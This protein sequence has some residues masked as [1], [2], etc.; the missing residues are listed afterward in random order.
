MHDILSCT[1]AQFELR[2][3]NGVEE[4][5]GRIEVYHNEQ[6]GTVCDDEWDANDAMVVCKQLNYTGGFARKEAAF[7]A[8]S[9]PIWLD[10]VVCSGTELTLHE[11]SH[12]GWGINDCS[13][14]ED[15]GVKCFNIGKV[16]LYITIFL[17]EL[18]N[19][20]IDLYYKGNIALII[21]I[22]TYVNISILMHI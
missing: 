15:A 18:V 11:C 3:V 22:M 1:S 10:G 17:L 2:L 21:L 14:G 9:G 16:A 12:L 4:G 6:W 8:G 20:Y 19:Y 7:G 5:E 13:H